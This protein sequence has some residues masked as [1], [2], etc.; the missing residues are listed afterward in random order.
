MP[1]Q[2]EATTDEI[3]EEELTPEELAEVSG[4]SRTSPAPGGHNASSAYQQNN[5][6]PHE[7]AQ[8]QQS[9]ANRPQNT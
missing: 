2:T 5:T 9:M 3:A 4:G 8:Y 7:D 1:D 6:T